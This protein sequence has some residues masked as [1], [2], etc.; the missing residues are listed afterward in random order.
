LLG[1]FLIPQRIVTLPTD[2][3]TLA[4]LAERL[5]IHAKPVQQKKQSTFG[6]LLSMGTGLAL[7][8]AGSY[9]TQQ[10]S[11]IASQQSASLHPQPAEIHHHDG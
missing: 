2:D 7:R 4:R 11:K 5:P 3:Q 10:L 9:L 6:W 8:A 1:Y